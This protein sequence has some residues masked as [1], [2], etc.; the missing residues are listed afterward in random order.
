M[1]YATARCESTRSDRAVQ[2][3]L[4]TVCRY[5]SAPVI[6]VASVCL[7]LLVTA[8]LTSC[9]FCLGDDGS[10][11]PPTVEQVNDALDLAEMA[12]KNGLTQLSMKAVSRAMEFGPPTIYR[13]RDT[14]EI[15][16]WGARVDTSVP[17][18]PTPL[19]EIRQ[20]IPRLVVSLVNHWTA[21]GD[22]SGAFQTLRAVMFPSRN[23][24]GVF[25]YESPPR[26]SNSQPDVIPAL[27]GLVP[28]LLRLGRELGE[29]ESLKLELQ[30]SE[31]SQTAEGILA[32]ILINAELGDRD[33]V[34][35][36]I[37]RLISLPTDELSRTVVTSAARVAVMIGQ[38]DTMDSRVAD[39]QAASLLRLAGA[40]LAEID[41]ADPDPHSIAT[42]VLVNAVRSGFAAGETTEAVDTL[43]TYLDL[44]TSARSES[45][46]FA[47]ERHRIEFAGRELCRRGLFREAQELLPAKDFA[48][49]A[50]IHQIADLRVE[51]GSIGPSAGPFAGMKQLETVPYRVLRPGEILQDMD[52][53][54]RI[55]ICRMDFELQQ[56]E[57]VFVLPDFRNVST[58]SSN[59]DGNIIAFDA[60]LPGQ[61]LASD[62]NIYLLRGE[63]QT[64]VSAGPGTLPSLSPEGTR[65]VCS[66]YSPRRGVWM[67]RSNGQDVRLLDSAGWGA[68]W[69]PDGIR[70][71]WIHLEGQE[72]SIVVHNLAEAETRTVATNR[73]NSGRQFRQGLQFSADG[74]LLAAIQ[75]GDPS[76]HELVV[77]SVDDPP[78]G[79]PSVPVATCK[80]GCEIFTPVSWAS[81]HSEL[82]VSSRIR[83]LEVEQLHRIPLRTAAEK[84]PIVMERISGQPESRRNSDLRFVPADGSFLYLSRPPRE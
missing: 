46:S 53:N 55:Q 41:S 56:S 17:T 66:R 16:H 52:L 25:F 82:F 77:L 7:R 35:A 71:A 39:S 80:T 9:M 65:L 5:L 64:L 21:Q 54:Q 4:K 49:F 48:T 15:V 2:R 30:S 78:G 26:V 73:S 44:K 8:L 58:L 3:F 27:D 36:E 6:P 79:N 37:A 10:A 50:A 28:E 61:V 23:S 29:L 12:D 74:T 32:C 76:G 20:R 69:S 75:T 18:P 34:T 14:G 42:A 81:D 59:R 1:S 43:K 19:E 84:V 62:A 11:V 47:A 70:I 45:E 60:T 51:T 40:R 33:Q 31:R 83:G 57:I 22:R 68:V 24:H 67:M 63:D 13:N 38:R 72:S